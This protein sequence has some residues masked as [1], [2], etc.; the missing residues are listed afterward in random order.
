MEKFKTSTHEFAVEIDNKDND[1]MKHVMNELVAFGYEK[2]KG[3]EYKGNT[4]L[5][6][7]KEL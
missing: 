5:I 3:I 6:Y 4:I 1:D 7:A 2:I